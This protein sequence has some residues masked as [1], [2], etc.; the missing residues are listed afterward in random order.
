[1]KFYLVQPGDTLNKIA[2]L[3]GV[4]EEEILQ[5]NDLESRIWFKRIKWS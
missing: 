2:S 4:A 1:M 5:A 3:Y